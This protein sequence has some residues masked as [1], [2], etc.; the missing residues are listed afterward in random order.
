MRGFKEHE[1]ADRFC[2]EDDE[3]RNFLR[4]R[5][6]HSN[7]PTP[8]L[9]PARPHRD[10]HHADRIMRRF[11]PRDALQT[12]RDVTEPPGRGPGVH[13]GPTRKLRGGRGLAGL[14]RRAMLPASR[15]DAGCCLSTTHQPSAAYRPETEGHDPRSWRL[16]PL[17]VR[18]QTPRFCSQVGASMSML[19]S[20][21]SAKHHERAYD[22][23]RGRAR[24]TDRCRD[25]CHDGLADA[26]HFSIPRPGAQEATVGASD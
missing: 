25:R 5:S 12:A 15:C 11:R 26:T 2:R 9:S 19:W 23:R 4:S 18:H 8:S 22:H 13:D 16:A 20:G 3:L 7:P 6:R 17:D 1:A 21:G 24:R 10:R 14:S